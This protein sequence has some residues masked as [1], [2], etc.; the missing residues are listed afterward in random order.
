MQVAP[1][2]RLV[3]RNISNN[4]TFNAKPKSSSTLNDKRGYNVSF[5]TVGN[6]TR[7]V[8]IQITVRYRNKEH[9]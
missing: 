5:L 4:N 2:S 8:A 9:S 1:F 7:T 6:G 3:A